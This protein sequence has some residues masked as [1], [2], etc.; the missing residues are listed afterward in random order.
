MTDIWSGA[1]EDSVLPGYGIVSIGNWILM[2]RI[3]ALP[4]NQGLIGRR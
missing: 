1:A 3:S 2:F 4:R